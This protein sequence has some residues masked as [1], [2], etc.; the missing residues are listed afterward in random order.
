VVGGITDLKTGCRAR[1]PSYTAGTGML[2][3][4]EWPGSDV[5]HRAACSAEINNEWSF[6]STPLMDS[7]RRQGQ[8]CL[9][10]GH[11]K[12]AVCAKHVFL[13]LFHES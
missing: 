12:R 6:A 7:W 4:V 3:G 11:A 10:L 1:P 2:S 8:R 9:L 13:S 5:G